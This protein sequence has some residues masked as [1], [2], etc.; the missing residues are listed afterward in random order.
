MDLISEIVS[1]AKANK[2][3][4][5]LPEGDEERTLKAAD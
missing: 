3:R 2:Q 1:R 4:I 5:V